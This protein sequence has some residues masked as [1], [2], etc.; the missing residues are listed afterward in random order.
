MNEFRKLYKK[1]ITEG[2]DSIKFSDFQY[3][4]EHL[5]FSCVRINGDHFIYRMDSIIDQINIQPNG[6]SAK[7][8]QVK[9]VRKIVKKYKL[10]GD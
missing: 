8:Y 6:N 10:G 4:I 5:G 7:E 1:I 3:F 2:S 9:Q